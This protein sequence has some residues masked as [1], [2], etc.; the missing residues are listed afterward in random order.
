MIIEGRAHK[1]GRDLLVGDIINNCGD[2]FRI[3]R[4]DAE[5]YTGVPGSPGRIAYT[6]SGDA[7][8]ILDAVPHRTETL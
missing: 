3:A 4:F 1:L 5:P 6:A 8:V 7:W 2:L